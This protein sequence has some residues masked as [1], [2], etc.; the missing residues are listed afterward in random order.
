MTRVENMY[1]NNILQVYKADLPWEKLSG[2][3]ILV[4]GATG[5]IGGRLVETLMAYPNKDYHV[6]GLGRNE[7]RA[8]ERFCA[9][10]DDTTFHFLQHD[11]TKPLDGDGIGVD[12]HYII[13]LASGASPNVMTSSP[14]DIMRANFVGTDNLLSYGMSHQ[15][16]RF[17]YV[18]SG[19]IYGEGKGE[20]F[21]E[22]DSGYVNSMLS[23][24]CYPSSKRAAETLCASYMSQYGV[25]V[26]VARP[27]HIYGASFTESDNRAY[28]QFI[29]NVVNGEDIVLKSPGLQYRS[30]LYVEDCVSALLY[31]LLKGECGEAYNVA[32]EDSCLSIRELAETIAELGGKQVVFAEPS[33][34]EIKGGSKITRAVFNT[35][36]LR[37][38]GW[39]PNYAYRS[40]LECVMQK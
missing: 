16:K 5:L 22:T 37:G 2:C 32:D 26:V 35:N 8:G 19:E 20:M 30:W 10:A 18:S 33:D 13:H 12:F 4:T 36:K 29:R 38:L 40:A 6:Y 3:N 34:S 9:F 31:I 17:L 1:D 23:R 28:A 11:V 27:C 7:K 14:V 21:S 39:K 24:S 15:I 25:N